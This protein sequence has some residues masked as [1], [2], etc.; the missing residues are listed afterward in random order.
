MTINS[1]TAWYVRTLTDHSIVR[2]ARRTTDLGKG[3]LYLIAT[4]AL[5]GYWR[6]L[7][8]NL[9][10]ARA[11]GYIFLRVVASGITADILKVLLA[12]TRPKLLYASNLSEFTFFRFGADYN[13]FPSGHATTV[14]SLSHRLSSRLLLPLH[15]FLPRLASRSFGVT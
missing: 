6:F 3:Y 12:R 13:S 5:Y 15:A 4:A 8:G 9:E 7:R 2:L 10:R 14:I 11:A 1:P